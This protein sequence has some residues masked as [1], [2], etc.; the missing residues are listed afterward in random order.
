MTEPYHH[1][2][3]VTRTLTLTLKFLP[4]CSIVVDMYYEVYYYYDNCMSA[5]LLVI[6]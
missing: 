1:F 5:I 4:A 3:S 2:A 6:I